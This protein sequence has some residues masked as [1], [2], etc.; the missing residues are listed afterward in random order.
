MFTSTDGSY[1]VYMTFLAV[2]LC[3]SQDIRRD[4]AK[5]IAYI[6]ETRLAR[7]L[8]TDRDSCS[9]RFSCALSAHSGSLKPAAMII[10][11]AFQGIAKTLEELAPRL[12][13]VFAFAICADVRNW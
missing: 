4:Y 10:I 12:V 2:M 6:Q 13:F 7:C 9:E 11:R 8:I 1:I 5:E 3:N